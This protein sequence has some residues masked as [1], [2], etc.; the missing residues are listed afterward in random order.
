[1]AE[2]NVKIKNFVSLQKSEVAEFYRSCFE[3]SSTLC[4]GA[5]VVKAIILSI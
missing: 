2:E 3:V 4:S 1:M 5:E